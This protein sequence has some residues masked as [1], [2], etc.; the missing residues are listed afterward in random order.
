[1]LKLAEQPEYQKEMLGYLDHEYRFVV[2]D[3][4]LKQDNEEKGLN[5]DSLNFLKA[6]SI[7]RSETSAKNGWVLAM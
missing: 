3:F 6:L 7:Q 5:L 2:P 4:N 1:L